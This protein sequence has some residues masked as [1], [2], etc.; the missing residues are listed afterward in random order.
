MARAAYG[1]GFT[2]ATTAAW[3]SKTAT[4]M[5]HLPGVRRAPSIDFG[6]AAADDCVAQPLHHAPKAGN[7]L[8]EPVHVAMKRPQEPDDGDPDDDDGDELV[9]HGASVAT[10]PRCV[11]GGRGCRAAPGAKAESSRYV[12]SAW[13]ARLDSNQ[14]PSD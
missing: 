6:T 2:S 3:V 7:P 10:P 11:N 12:G 9:R 4:A 5:A 14:G 8:A 1:S 13:Y